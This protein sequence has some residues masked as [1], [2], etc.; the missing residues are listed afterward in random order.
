MR[1]PLGGWNAG[2][3]LFWVMRAVVWNPQHTLGWRLEDISLHMWSIDAIILLGTTYKSDQPGATCVD[4]PY[5]F[6]YQFGWAAG[7]YTNK[8][9]G[10]TVLLKR[11]RFK[12]AHVSVYSPPSQNK[13]RGGHWG[14]G[15]ALRLSCGRLL[16]TATRGLRKRTAGP[17]SQ[18]E[19]SANSG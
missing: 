13:G 2:G 15:G 1:G 7:R 4:L 18:E 5:H 6:A 11:K 12:K 14:K 19:V 10:V 16:H 17:H 3:L 9:A 8:S